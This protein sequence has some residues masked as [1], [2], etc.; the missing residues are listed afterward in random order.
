MSD[1]T[2]SRAE[3]S[4][5]ENPKTTD[6]A[7]LEQEVKDW[8]EF[9]KIEYA[10]YQQHKILMDVVEECVEDSNNLDSELREKIKSIILSQRVAQIRL[11]NSSCDE[12]ILGV[13]RNVTELTYSEGNKLQS[14]LKTKLDNRRDKCTSDVVKIESP[15][16][17]SSEDQQL[18][19]QRNQLIAEHQAYTK[20]QIVLLEL[21]EDLRNLKT[22]TVPTVADEK[23]KEY[24][25]KSHINNLK[26]ELMKDKYSIDI[27][28]ESSHSLKAYREVMEDM[29]K[30]KVELQRE[31]E[32][33]KD[34]KQKYAQ[35]SCKEYDDIVR[36]Y[37]QY[38]VSLEKKKQ[39]LELFNS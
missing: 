38:K 31:I 6:Q 34:L 20:N 7:A 35:V 26:S 2:T 25:C 14:C 17:L 28:M 30:Q 13:P 36:S 12:T 11:D 39:M 8:T 16:E 10:Q 18:F 33:L 23:Y 24:S 27:F 19:D 5:T 32:R 15:F 21:L 29:K 9:L 1:A 3:T 37:R 22:S 4:L